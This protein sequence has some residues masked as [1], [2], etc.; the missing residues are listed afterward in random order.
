MKRVFLLLFLIGITEISYR[1]KLN[2]WPDDALCV[3]MENPLP[4]SYIVEE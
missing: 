3:W 1:D 4:H 2:D